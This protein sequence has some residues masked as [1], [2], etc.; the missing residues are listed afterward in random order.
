[1]WKRRSGWWALESALRSLRAEAR[2]DLVHGIVSRIQAEPTRGRRPWS[3]LAFA[4]AVSVFILGSFASFGGLSYAAPG[5]GNTVAA[6]KQVVAGHP[7]KV[8]IHKSSAMSQYYMPTPNTPS[9]P[10][11]PPKAATAVKTPPVAS[12]QTLPFTGISLLG[13]L[14]ASLFLVS[15]GLVLRRRERRS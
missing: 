1:M 15:V 10:S 8:T 11:T 6:V 13:T 5:V 2:P 9:T 4:A 14:V 3:R 7:L 12:G